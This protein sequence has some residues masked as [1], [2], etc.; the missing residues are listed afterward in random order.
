MPKAL[1]GSQKTSGSGPAVDA[2]TL[3][4]LI[5]DLDSSDGAVRRSASET[6]VEIGRPAVEPLTS[7]LSKNPN[8]DARWEAAKALDE[9]GDPAAAHD[10]V[11]ALED[12]SFGV[13]WLAAEGL[14]GLGRAGM[15]PLLEAL[16]ERSSS[17]WLRQGAHHVLQVLSKHNL[18][19]PLAPVLAALED[20]EPAVEVPHAAL[21][22]LD[23]L[24]KPTAR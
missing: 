24:A 19:N 4:S 23:A 16:L 18:P 21:A 10:M 12:R 15:P 2:K 17:I 8:D 1:S 22:A 3:Q 7:V 5:G 13:R 9:I 20:V 6:L 14:I 11:R